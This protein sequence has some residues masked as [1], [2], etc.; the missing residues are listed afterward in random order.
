M[1]KDKPEHMVWIDIETT[2]LDPLEEGAGILEIYGVIT[3]TT[4]EFNFVGEPI[5]LIRGAKI[6]EL[7][8]N[9][10]VLKMHARSG[11]FEDMANSSK[12]DEKHYGPA[13]PTSKIPLGLKLRRWLHK[14]VTEEHA[15][16]YLAG[17]SVHFDRK[18]L[19]VFTSHF[20]SCLSYR[21]Y[22]VSSLWLQHDIVTNEAPLG[23]NETTLHRAKDDILRSIAIARA[24]A[25]GT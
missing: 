17:S 7:R 9:P 19:E 5:H 10:F 23:V 21:N 14:E 12:Y 15:K 4:P 3:D 1:S 22:D 20:L 8:F 2:G 6:E 25:K 18:W 24:C 13:I 11:L 16:P